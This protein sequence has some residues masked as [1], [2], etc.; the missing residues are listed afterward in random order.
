[1]LQIIFP[2]YWS[3][4]KCADYCTTHELATDL[5]LQY[6]FLDDRYIAW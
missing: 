6:M 2:S 5:Q 1:M 3:Y 4:A